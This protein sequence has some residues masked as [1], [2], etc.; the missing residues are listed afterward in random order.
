MKI[1]RPDPAKRTELKQ[2]RDE[3]GQACGKQT[4]IQQALLNQRSETVVQPDSA[5]R[6][7]IEQLTQ[8]LQRTH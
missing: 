6:T 3:C 8:Q 4:A 7:P 5:D 1:I 2:L